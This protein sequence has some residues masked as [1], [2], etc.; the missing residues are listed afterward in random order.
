VK[1]RKLWEVYNGAIEANNG[2]VEAH[3]GAENS[4]IGESG[5]FE[6]IG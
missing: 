3:F 4:L 5:R 2:I 1:I 6:S